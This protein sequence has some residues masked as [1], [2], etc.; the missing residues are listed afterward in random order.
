MY[1]GV[2][3]LDVHGHVSSPT[4]AR[5]FVSMLM[6]SNT[7]MRSPLAPG[8]APTGRGPNEHTD[9][10]YM[11]TAKMH[12]DFMSARNIDVQ[13]IG[14]R[15]FLMLGWMQPHLL[16]AWTRFVNDCIHKQCTLIPDRF[17]GAAQLPQN[18]DAP[19]LSHCLDELRRCVDDLGFKAVYLSPD[20]KGLRSTPGMN[21]SYWDP[22]YAECQKRGL[23][24]IVH[25]TNCQ[26][27]RIGIIPQN[28]QVGFMFEQFLATQL[29]SHG[30]VFDRFPEL[31]VVI[32]HGGGA[33]NR[34]I[35]TDP[36]LGQKDYTK[37]LFF[38][39]CVH[40]IPVLEATI[41]Q[42]GVKNTLFGTEAPGSGGAVR[43]ETGKTA[44]DLVPVISAIDFLSEDDKLQI[45]NKGPMSF[46]PAF[47]DVPEAAHA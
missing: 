38:D 35:P 22:I 25:G 12:A 10:A 19:D 31:K 37:N 36:H 17:I 6:A 29:L 34:F 43:P 40:D 1:N 8:A 3:V 30:D 23:P 28:Y 7:A 41:K 21:T 44:D 18:S 13:I 20:P 14:P 24:I 45:F 11:A 32:C 46:C 33:L 9:E 26:D 5:A 47:A 42:R 15:P 39:T 27:Q 16:P 2:K 4:A